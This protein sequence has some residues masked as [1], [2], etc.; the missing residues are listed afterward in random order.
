M[1]LKPYMVEFG[2]CVMQFDN[3]V[4]NKILTYNL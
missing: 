1:T 3:I 4:C 2:M